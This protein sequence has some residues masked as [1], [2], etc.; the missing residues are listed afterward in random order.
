MNNPD[1]PNM[2]AEV[3]DHQT[4]RNFPNPMFLR[5][6]IEFKREMAGVSEDQGRTQ[7]TMPPVE[8]NANFP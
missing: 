6:G 8:Q 5:G 3:R 4:W 2:L 1:A 7:S